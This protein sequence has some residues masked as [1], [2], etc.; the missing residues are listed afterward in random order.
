MFSRVQTLVE[1]FGIQTQVSSELLEILLAERSLVFTG[2]AVE[3]L[4][5]IGPKRVLLGCTF[6]GFPCPLRLGSKK[7]EV[8]VAKA[9]DTGLDVLFIDLASRASGKS[10]AIGSLEIA[11]LNNRDRRVRVALKVTGLLDHALHQFSLACR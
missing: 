8:P 11:E 9:H 10:P 1:S 5:V 4:V 6:T 7:C 2:L 3:D